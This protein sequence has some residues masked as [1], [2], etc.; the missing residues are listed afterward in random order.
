MS[1]LNEAVIA[2][3]ERVEIIENGGAIAILLREADGT[4]SAIRIGVEQL[5]D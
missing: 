2:S 1:E 3:F 5:A 4:V